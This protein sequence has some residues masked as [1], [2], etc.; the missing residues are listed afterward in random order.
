MY[1]LC[2]F[3]ELLIWQKFKAILALRWLKRLNPKPQILKLVERLNS[4]VPSCTCA[5]PVV[6]F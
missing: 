3:L 4:T 6:H 2:F 1:I 5:F